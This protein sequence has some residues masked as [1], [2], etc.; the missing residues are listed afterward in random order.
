[1]GVQ[2]AF[3]V[4]GNKENPRWIR[5]WQC[6]GLVWTTRSAE[7]SVSPQLGAKRWRRTAD[8][9]VRA[10]AEAGWLADG[11]CECVSGARARETSKVYFQVRTKMALSRSFPRAIWQ[12]IRGCF[13]PREQRP[14]TNPLTMRLF[15]EESTMPR[16]SFHW[17]TS[18]WVGREGG[19]ALWWERSRFEREITSA[20]AGTNEECKRTLRPILCR[21]VFPPRKLLERVTRCH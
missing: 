2:F 8:R 1:M 20:L 15:S 16:Q 6:W 5:Y 10:C 7:R 14:S 17:T 11:V 9:T 4:S 19:K 13:P 3:S 12:R 18:S 21:P